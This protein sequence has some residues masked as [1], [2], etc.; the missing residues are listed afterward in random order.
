MKKTRRNSRISERQLRNII[1]EELAREHLIRE[2]FMDSLAKPFKALEQK[3]KEEI[4]KKSEEIIA[5]LKQLVEQLKSSD[6]IKE[7]NQFMT[8]LSSEDTGGSVDEIVSQVPD[9]AALYKDV[10]ELK[11]IDPMEIVA[12][13]TSSTKAEGINRS[14]LATQL[15]LLDEHRD[16]TLERYN[17]NTPT[18]L[19]ES[20]LLTAFTAW[21]TFEKTVV[22]GLGLMYWALKFL[23][24]ACG[25]LGFKNASASLKKHSEKVHHLEDAIIETTVFPMSVQYAAY[26]VYTK[27]KGG[28]SMS[29]EEFKNPKNKEAKESRKATFKVLKFALFMPMIVDA[30]VGLAQ[31][32]GPT[33]NSFGSFFKTAKYGAKVA[34]ETGAAAKTIANLGSAAAEVS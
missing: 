4:A 18:V 31:A 16:Q 2:G 14:S 7:A 30:L 19:S 21:W 27:M 3:V 22:G 25:K 32:L 1:R 13:D 15:I 26:A 34:S 24:W 9:L 33:F 11:S 5:N 8:L 10:K 29:F 28:K 20:I 12:S 6:A 17:K 23:S